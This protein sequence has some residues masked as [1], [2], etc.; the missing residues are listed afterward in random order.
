MVLPL[1]VP[2]PS[3]VGTRRSGPATV[4]LISAGPTGSAVADAMP[5]AAR[6]TPP[7][8]RSAWSCH[9]RYRLLVPWMTTSSPESPT[10]VPPDGWLP[11][12]TRVA[13]AV[14]SAVR[15]ALH[16][17]HGSPDRSFGSGSES[18]AP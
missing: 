16:T 7:A 8:I 1:N 12:R 6:G 5:S 18:G 10:A 15:G 17:L 4:P 13:G 2:S 9:N 14:L 3:I 11:T